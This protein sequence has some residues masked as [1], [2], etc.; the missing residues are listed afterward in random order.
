M[1]SLDNVSGSFTERNK[2]IVEKF[3]NGEEVL[4]RFSFPSNEVLSTVN[5]IIALSLGKLDLVFLLE[6]VITILRE[7]ILNAIKANGKR[8]FFQNAGASIED[9]ATYDTVMNTF[10]TDIIGDFSKLKTDLIK[11][12]YKVDFKLQKLENS[13]RIK[14]ENNAVILPKEEKRIN[15]RMT[16]ARKFKDFSDAYE[17]MYDETEGAGLGIIL[18]ILLLKN[19]GVSPDNFSIKAVGEKT[20]TTLELPLQLKTPDTVTQIKNE[21]L[22]EVHLL[23]TFPQNVM[24]LLSMCDNPDASIGMMA[25]KIKTDPSLTADILKL[26]NSAGFISAK[27]I[28]NINEA[29]MRIGLTNLKYILIA[30]SSRKIMDKR[31]KKFEQIWNHCYKVGFYA[32]HLA[33]ALKKNSVAEAAFISSVLHDL[34]KIVLL[35]VDLS[36]THWIADFVKERGIRNTTILEEVSIGISHSSIGELIAEKWNFADFLKEG[37]SYHHSP[38]KASDQNR[39]IVFLTYL[40][41]V[42]CGVESRK[43]D[44][45]YLDPIVLDSFNING[46]NEIKQ[47]HEKIKTAFENQAK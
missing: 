38:L 40:A 3:S 23:P 8:L 2:R 18:T 9:P 1:E 42:L 19:L 26:A 24:D 29:L 15:E 17:E 7:C 6:T 5:G 35:S 32:R 47:L 37:I 25:E 22:K 28:E 36:L 20:V 4:L 31:Y 30:A 27:R 46:E 34:G 14:I 43:Y 41:N 12:D 16:N 44:Y 33:F 45:Y 13:F 11:S 10:K 21:I 39:D